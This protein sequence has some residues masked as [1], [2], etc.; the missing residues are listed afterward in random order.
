M[1]LT[2]EQLCRHVLG[3]FAHFNRAFFVPKKVHLC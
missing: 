3:Q 1:Q 2:S